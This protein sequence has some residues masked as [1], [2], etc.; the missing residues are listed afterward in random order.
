MIVL[1]V[2]GRR[3]SVLSS[4]QRIYRGYCGIGDLGKRAISTCSAKDYYFVG[5][6][7]TSAWVK[8]SVDCR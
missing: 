1:A 6:S 7:A 4:T 2:L 8:G 3:G 5:Y